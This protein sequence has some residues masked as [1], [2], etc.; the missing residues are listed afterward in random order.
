MRSHLSARLGALALMLSTLSC[1]EGGGGLLERLGLSDGPNRPGGEDVTGDAGVSIELTSG[2]WISATGQHT[3]SGVVSAPRGVASITITVRAACLHGEDEAP[4][5]EDCPRGEPRRLALPGAG[6]S[7]LPFRERLTLPLDTTRLLITARDRQ[8]GAATQ[9]RDLRVDDPDDD[10]YLI[11]SEQE[12]IRAIGDQGHELRGD[13][14]IEDVSG[15]RDL[16]AMRGVRSIHGSL[17]I[18][19]NPDLVSLTGLEQLTRVRNTLA[20]GGSP[21]LSDITALAALSDVNDLN[22]FGAALFFDLAALTNLSQVRGV[23]NLTR[24]N[25]IRLNLPS[26]PWIMIKGLR[27]A[28]NTQLRELNLSEH[29]SLDIVELIHQPHLSD[30]RALPLGRYMDNLTVQGLSAMTALGPLETTSII[31]LNITECPQLT[32]LS[33]LEQVTQI[34]RLRLHRN[35]RL[36]D[37]SALDAIVSL[38]ELL[39]VRENPALSACDAQEFKQ[40]LPRPP[41]EVVIE[42]NDERALPCASEP[43][44]PGGPREPTPPD[45][46]D[47]GVVIPG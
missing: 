12:L 8:N 43:H 34:N 2:R 42:Q 18:L 5:V 14:Y 10:N 20:I 46:T 29:L 24:T 16:K 25:L 13:Y 32:T 6:A 47:T 27:L 37:I 17:Q 44:D 35:E 19:N 38:D 4:N 23:L 30:L 36:A 3:L 31:E 22:I 26:H 1:G 9:V 11:T 41:Q 33:G 15:L 28:R 40:R 39:S 45:D 21:K 7:T